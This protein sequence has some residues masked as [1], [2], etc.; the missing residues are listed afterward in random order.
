[1]TTLDS[2]WSSAPRAITDLERPD[3][4]YLTSEHNCVFFGEYTARVGYEHSRTNDIISNLKKSVTK[5]GKPVLISNS[6][7]TLKPSR[8]KFHE[9]WLLDLNLKFCVYML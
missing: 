7:W 4:H 1:M 6:S 9:L 8:K 2:S 3:H 5:K